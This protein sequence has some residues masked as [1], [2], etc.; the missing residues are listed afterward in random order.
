M[1]YGIQDLLSYVPLTKAVQTVKTGIP[2]VLPDAFW[3]VTEDVPGDRARLVEFQG[4]RKLARVAPY[5]SPPRQV[6]HLPLS[7]KALVLLHT[8]EEMAFRDELFRILRQWE[9]YKPQQQWAKQELARQAAGF[10]QRFDNLRL[11]AIQGNL[12]NAGVLW[13]DGDG[14]MLA[15]SSGAK[16]T[17]D[18]GVPANNK[19]QLNGIISASWATAGTDIVSQVNALKIR[20]VQTTGY[21]LKYAFYGKNI[22]GYF[23]AN[24]SI[25]NYWWRNQQFSNSYLGTGRLPEGM[26]ELTWIPA[27]NAFYE[28]DAGTVVE[29][30]PGDQVTFTPDINAETYTLYQGSIHVPRRFGMYATAEQALADVEEAF[31]MFRYAYMKINP[32][33]I[34]DVIG[35]TFLPRFKVPAAYYF[36]D[37]TP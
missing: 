28:D 14:G 19:N 7:D 9:Q 34:I 22:P 27:Q 5:G 25:Q 16:L 24:T 8:T 31:G 2:K 33:Q 23:N 26:L 17:V 12:A 10:R 1:A 15:S 29:Q 11:A 30:F 21:P 20:A 35:D 36:A 32:V 37:V 3:S 13:F 6:D 18:Q 4:T